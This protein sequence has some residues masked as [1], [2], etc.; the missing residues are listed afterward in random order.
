MNEIPSAERQEHAPPPAGA[1]VDLHNASEPT[2]KPENS[3]AGD[4]CRVSSC[5]AL[6]F[7]EKA[8][9]MLDD[10]MQKKGLGRVVLNLEFG[11]LEFRFGHCSI[12]L[13]GLKKEYFGSFVTDRGLMVPV[14]RIPQPIATT[15]AGKLKL[16]ALGFRNEELVN[17]S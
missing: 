17:E 6:L 4:G 8:V 2:G 3:A 5:C 9:P 11:V 13:A 1:S 12:G 14:P 7:L 10:M 15:E 16:A